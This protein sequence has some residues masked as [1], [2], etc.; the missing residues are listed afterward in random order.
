MSHRIDW[1]KDVLPF[2]WRIAASWISGYF[3][4]YAFT[5]LI[6][7]HQGATEAGRFGMAMTVFNSVSAVGMSWVNAKSP[8]FGMHISR[9]ERQMLNALFLSVFKR[10]IIFAV[11]AS[12]V[13]CAVAFVLARL[14]LHFMRRVA[15]PAV[16]AI[17]AA[18]CVINC[19]IFSVATYMRAHREEPMLPLSVASGLATALIAYFGSMHS[20]LLMSIAYLVMNLTLA[21]PWSMRLFLQYFRRT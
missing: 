2:Q 14:D 21:L 3:I 19:V 11:G 20:V 17:L 4:F 9:K 16:I 6:F 15:D 18:V 10:S 13:V 1:R 12:V 8:A 7:S 5:P